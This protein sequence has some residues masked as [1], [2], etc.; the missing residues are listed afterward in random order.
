MG[1]ACISAASGGKRSGQAV[2][3]PT[4]MKGAILGLAASAGPGSSAEALRLT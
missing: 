3:M 2:D 1:A 4:W